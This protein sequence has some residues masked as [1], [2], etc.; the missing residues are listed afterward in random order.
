MR[1]H[2]KISPSFFAVLLITYFLG[3]IKEYL[4]MFLILFCHEMSHLTAICFEDIKI[5]YVKIEPFGITIRLKERIFKNPQKEIVMAFAGPL[6]NFIFA[7]GGYKIN[8]TELQYFIYANLSMGIFNLLPAYPL[9]GGR[10]LKAYLSKKYGYIKSY[11]FVLRLS[12]LIAVLITLTGVYILYITKFNFLISITGCFLYFNVLTEKNYSYFY[13]MQEISEY[14]KKNR[15]IEKMPVINIAVNKEFPVRKILYD[16]SFTKYY[17]FT[18][19]DNGKKIATLTE[20][21][22]IESLLNS[23]SDVKIKNIIDK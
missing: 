13:L 5:S 15:H 6:I 1:K 14:K 11:R 18:V 10:I 9:D 8:Y 20:G 7:F 16:L 2:F 21:E 22:L 3:F 4:L 19:I 17:I 23:S 12:K